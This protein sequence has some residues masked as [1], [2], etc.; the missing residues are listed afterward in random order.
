TAR[1]LPKT[2]AVLVA[3]LIIAT[4]LAIVPADFT[5]PA[6]GTLQPAAQRD[7]FAD[8]DAVVRAVR[9][10]HGARVEAGDVL[11]ELDSTD[12]AVQLADVLGQRQ[13]AGERLS[14]LNRQR[15]D[16]AV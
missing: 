10:A 5:V 2:V 1:N 15:L 7:V 13:T 14:A 16:A 3:A 12:L 8:V 6:R 11:V 9:V 4:G